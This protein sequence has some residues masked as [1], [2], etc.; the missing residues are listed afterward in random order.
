[1]SKLFTP[2]APA[3]QGQVRTSVQ[4]IQHASPRRPQ[5][6]G[7]QLVGGYPANFGVGKGAGAGKVSRSSKPKRAKHY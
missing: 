6:Q 1:M 7:G 3:K 4:P 2:K 5:N